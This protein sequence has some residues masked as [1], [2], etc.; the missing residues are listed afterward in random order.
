MSDFFKCAACGR[1]VKEI[2]EGKGELSC[3]GH[4]M[5]QLGEFKSVDELLTYAIEKE[6]EA[7]EFYL[8]W[9]GKLATPHLQ[10]VFRSFAAE[11]DKHKEKLERVKSGS[12]FRPS[13]AEITDLRIVD[14]LV[15]LVPTPGIDYQEALIIAMK[16]EKASFRLYNDLAQLTHDESLKAT[17]FA[18]AQE[19]AKHKLRLET[20]YEKDIYGEN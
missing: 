11:E 15:D 10:E 4:A 17:F 8:E 14:Y 2:Y 16:R 20:E 3:C 13:T 19:E 18:L 5:T 7:R 9:A 12:L 6:V 1:M